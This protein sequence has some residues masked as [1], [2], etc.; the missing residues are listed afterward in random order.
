MCCGSLLQ[1]SSSG[2][3]S[4]VV[5]EQCLNAAFFMDFYNEFLMQQL[6]VFPSSSHQKWK[7]SDEAMGEYKARFNSFL[8]Q[9]KHWFFF[10]LILVLKQIKNWRQFDLKIYHMLLFSFRSRM[11]QPC[12]CL[13]LCVS[14]L[15]VRALP[16]NGTE[17]PKPT[18]TTSKDS[19]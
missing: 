15:F 10:L 13:L 3:V 7:S 9:S 11:E 18:S 5:F 4:T 14:F 2:P 6:V 1:S 12:P 16:P 19:I 17:L 8:F